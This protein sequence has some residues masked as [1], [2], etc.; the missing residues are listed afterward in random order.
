MN[1]N[2]ISFIICFND[3]NLCDECILYINNLNN[4][5]NFEIEI[6]LI[7]DALS[8]TEGYN[9]AMKSTDAKYKVYLHQDTFIVNK[10]FIINIIDIFK[11]NTIGMIGVAGTRRL[12][13]SGIWWESK[14]VV[15]KIYDNVTGKLQLSFTDTKNKN[16]DEVEAIDGLIIITQ[17]DLP[18]REDIFQ[19]WHFYDISQSCEFRLSKYKV[20]VPN[21]DR[22]WC[23]HDCGTDIMDISYEKFR[24]KFLLEYY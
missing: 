11:D 5:D 13:Q 4:P 21:Q 19:G 7:D 2:K 8:M 10:D 6:I 12:P 14:E 9:R 17:Y 1:G 3:K 16:Y 24:K 23:I 22:P 18:W 15:G 20:V